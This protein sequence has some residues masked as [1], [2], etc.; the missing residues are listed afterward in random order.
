MKTKFYTAS[1]DGALMHWTCNKMLTEVKE[2]NRKRK[3]SEDEGQ[4]DSEQE[5]EGRLIEKK[6]F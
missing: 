4:E 3:L 5:N 1:K 2:K 6:I